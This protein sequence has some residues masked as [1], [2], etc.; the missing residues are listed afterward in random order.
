MKTEE[1]CRDCLAGLA[2]TTV[3]LSQGGEAL[4]EKCMETIDRLIPAGRTPPAI[5]NILLRQIREATGLVDPF[6][7]MKE[8]EFREGMSAYD[9]LKDRA[10][11]SLESCL[12]L[13]ALGNSADFFAQGAF[14]DG[15]F[16]VSPS[17]DKIE[18]EIYNTSEE[19]LVLGDNVGDF[20]FDLP[21]VHYLE[22]AGKRVYYA[23]RQEPVQNDLSVLDVER[24]RL[25][26]LFGRIISTGT[27][28]VGIVPGA[29]RGKIAE[30]WSG[31]G[32]VVAKGMG[33]FETLSEDRNPRTVVHIL[34]VKCPAVAYSVGQPVGAYLVTLRR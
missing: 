9:R 28:E 4:F 11:D 8:R 32:L 23:V 5:A 1:P 27:G 20:I 31:D 7:A 2:R 26:D 18:E 30:L 25:N 10:G 6:G 12:K 16:S 29:L 21:L 3:H 22:R 19:A 15:I 13:S 17:V 14:D 24:F 33:N 34:K